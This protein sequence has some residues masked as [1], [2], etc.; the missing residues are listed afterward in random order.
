MPEQTITHLVCDCDGV[1]IDSE[2]VALQALLAGVAA[3]VEPA[4]HALLPGLIKPRLGLKLE[5]LLLGLFQELELPPPDAAGLAALRAQV[6]LACDTHLRAIPGVGEALAVIALPKAV[7]SNSS[8]ARVSSALARTGLAPLFGAR[9]YT[10]DTVGHAKPHP[11]VYLAAVKGF[12]VAAENCAA[13]EDSITGVTAASAAGLLVFGFTGGGHVP[14]GQA[15]LLLEAG[16]TATFDDMAQ[17]PA[18]LAAY[19]G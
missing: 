8:H 19:G 9:I 2:A 4:R 1:L 3:L 13:V 10:Y 14:Q 17:L 11:G 7:A 18:L 5:P 6:E 12:G 15:A 16:A